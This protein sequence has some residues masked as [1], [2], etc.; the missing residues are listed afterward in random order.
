[1][2]VLPVNDWLQLGYYNS[3]QRME[4]IW[5]SEGIGDWAGEYVKPSIVNMNFDWE[6]AHLVVDLGSITLKAGI[7]FNTSSFILSAYLIKIRMTF[8]YDFQYDGVDYRAELGIDL[9]L[10]AG[11]VESWDN[12]MAILMEPMDVLTPVDANYIIRISR[13]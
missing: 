2:S 13:R 6:I 7:G 10:K 1:M 3:T 9:S 12:L 4:F 8:Y 5:G 11:D